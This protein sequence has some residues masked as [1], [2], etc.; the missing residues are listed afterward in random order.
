MWRGHLAAARCAVCSRPGMSLW[1]CRRR[2]RRALYSPSRSTPH[3]INDSTSHLVSFRWA[4]PT[5]VRN[6]TSTLVMTAGS[7]TNARQHCLAHAPLTLKL[8]CRT[9][10]TWAR[11]L[12]NGTRCSGSCGVPSILAA[13]VRRELLALIRPPRQMAAATR[14]RASSVPVLAGLALSSL[15]FGTLLGPG[16]GVP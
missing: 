15:R 1:Q 2:V 7:C 6:A 11:L 8:P 3:F 5:T 12:W 14:L 9:I 16:G 4:A 13:S 10:L